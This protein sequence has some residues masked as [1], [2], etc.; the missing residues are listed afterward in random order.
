MQNYQREEL[1]LLIFILELNLQK[2]AF[3]SQGK[4]VLIVFSFPS[5][6]EEIQD[7]ILFLLLIDFFKMSKIMD[8]F[9]NVLRDCFSS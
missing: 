6:N 8:F 1:F 3:N 9:F 7:A 4:I 2:T 5:C